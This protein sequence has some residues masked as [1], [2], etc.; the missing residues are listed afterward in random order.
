MRWH[1]SGQVRQ[2]PTRERQRGRA[3]AVREASSAIDPPSRAPSVKRS[4]DEQ[5]PG[6]DTLLGRLCEARS[7]IGIAGPQSQERHLGHP[8]TGWIE[9]VRHRLEASRGTSDDPAPGAERAQREQLAVHHRRHH[10]CRPGARDDDLCQRGETGPHLGA[11]VFGPAQRMCG[12]GRHQRRRRAH[13]IGPRPAAARA[14]TPARGA[15]VRPPP[16]GPR[17]ARGRPSAPERSAAL[18]PS[19]RWRPRPEPHVQPQ[20]PPSPARRGDC[21]GAG[22]G[23]TRQLARS[24]RPRPPPRARPGPAT[25]ASS[26]DPRGIP[27]AGGLAPAA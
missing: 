11:R 6:S 20:R 5:D 27:C 16:A 19:R 13:P 7:M 3:P 14:A 22:A 24:R 25:A 23:R 12:V 4:A 8:E 21:S 10:G 15:G 18:I 9:A 1:R 2:R 17:P 26:L